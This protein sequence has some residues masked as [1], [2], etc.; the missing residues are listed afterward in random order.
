MNSPGLLL[1]AYPRPI[2]VSA[3]ILDFFPIEGTRKT[4]PGEVAAL[5]RRFGHGDRIAG[6]RGLPQAPVSAGKP[7]AGVA[8]LDRAFGRPAAARP[9]RSPSPAGGPPF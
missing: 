7:G 4:I 6:Q 9:R 1:L 3:A 2:H 5:Y 8:F